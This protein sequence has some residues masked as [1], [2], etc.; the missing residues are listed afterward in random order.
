MFDAGDELARGFSPE[1]LRPVNEGVSRGGVWCF[2]GPVAGGKATVGV[3]FVAGG[4]AK[5]C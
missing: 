1:G 4:R 2:V 5:S 3:F